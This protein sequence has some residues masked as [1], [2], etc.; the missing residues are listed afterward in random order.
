MAAFVLFYKLCERAEQTFSLFMVDKR[1]PSTTMALWS[2]VMR[3]LSLLGSTYA[4]FALS[5][6][7]ADPKKLLTRLPRFAFEYSSM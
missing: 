3:T 1:V 7:S 4:G 6:K 5:K 2:T